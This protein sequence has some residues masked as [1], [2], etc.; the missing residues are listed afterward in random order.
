MP[1]SYNCPG[2]IPPGPKPRFVTA[3]EVALRDDQ[4]ASIARIASALQ[5]S[6]PEVVRWFVD[7]GIAAVESTPSFKQ[8]EELSRG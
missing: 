2:R 3:L 1:A 7:S 4:E 5:V 6:R 8:L